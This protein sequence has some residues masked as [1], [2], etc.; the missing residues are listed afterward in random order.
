MLWCVVWGVGCGMWL[1]RARWCRHG[2]SMST[3]ARVCVVVVVGGG[4][5]ASWTHG[6]HVARCSY[7]AQSRAWE[8]MCNGPT[9]GAVKADASWNV[10]DRG[11]SALYCKSACSR[12]WCNFC[13]Q[14]VLPFV[15]GSDMLDG[16]TAVAAFVVVVVYQVPCLALV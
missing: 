2:L 11:S 13:P 16:A 7:D 3:R 4:V 15:S 6:A 1:L 14:S 5:R 9:Q 8:T 10:V 12:Y